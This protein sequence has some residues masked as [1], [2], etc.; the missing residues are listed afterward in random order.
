MFIFTLPFP[1]ITS[2]K[3]S[4]LLDVLATPSVSAMSK[5]TWRKLGMLESVNDEVPEQTRRKSMRWL[6]G[7][8]DRTSYHVHTIVSATSTTC[9]PR[10][11]G[12]VFLNFSRRTGC[13]VRQPWGRADPRRKPRARCHPTASASASVAAT[14]SCPLPQQLSRPDHRGLG[15]LGSRKR[16]EVQLPLQAPAPQPGTVKARLRLV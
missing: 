2:S 13:T 5:S 14:P 11:T 3:S 1:S 7:F 8:Q 6:R 10:F 15:L 4:I 9:E 16:P 12:Q